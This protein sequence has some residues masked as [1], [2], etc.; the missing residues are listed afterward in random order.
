MNLAGQLILVFFLGKERYAL[1]ARQV[2]RV[3]PAVPCRPL[4]QAPAYV[5]GLLNF[6]GR[7]V[8][9]LDL[10]Q[11]CLGRP[12][13]PIMSTRILLVPYQETML[14]VMVES[15]IETARYSMEAFA[16]TGIAG[17]PFLGG[18][19]SVPEGTVQLLKV[20]DLFSDEVKALLSP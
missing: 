14:G 6:E 8:A 2:L 11:L 15:L 4:P 7:Q 3:I 20:T 18:V 19:Q 12:C 16:P 13:E 17:P 1:D 9:V 5:V 10:C